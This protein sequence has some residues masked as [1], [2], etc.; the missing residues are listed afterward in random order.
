[1]IYRTSFL[2]IAF[3]IVSCISVKKSIIRST[4]VFSI[5]NPEKYSVIGSIKVTNLYIDPLASKDKFKLTSK[6]TL[7]Q[8]VPDALYD[9][10]GDTCWI[11]DFDI[12]PHSLKCLGL[13]SELSFDI[14]V[15][16]QK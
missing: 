8:I 12:I 15:L 11:T 6:K 2:L 16:K 13:C 10:D 14:V 3:L 9:L 4:D 5:P 1:M 7:N